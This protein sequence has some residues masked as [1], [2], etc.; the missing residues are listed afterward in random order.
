MACR[1]RGLAAASAPSSSLLR[2][3]LAASGSLAGAAAVGAVGSGAP[4]RLPCRASLGIGTR[5]ASL[6]ALSDPDRTGV[7]WIRTVS[8]AKH[9]QLLWVRILEAQLPV[10]ASTLGSH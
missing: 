1:V 5:T 3:R 9:H 2:S 10:E 7:I 4:N 8:A 6:A